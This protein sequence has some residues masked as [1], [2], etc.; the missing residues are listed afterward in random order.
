MDVTYDVQAVCDRTKYYIR[1]KI[2]YHYGEERHCDG[3]CVS[4]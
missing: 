4:L 3:I 2:E 1:K